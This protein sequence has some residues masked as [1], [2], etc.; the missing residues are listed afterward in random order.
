[1]RG[2]FDDVSGLRHSQ[3]FGQIVTKLKIINVYI[4]CTSTRGISFISLYKMFITL[5]LTEYLY[6]S[7]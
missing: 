3:A 7:P 1:M 5:E 2:G 6:A 4:M